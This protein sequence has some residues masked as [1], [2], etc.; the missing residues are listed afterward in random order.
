[1]RIHLLKTLPIYFQET[2]IGLKTFEVRKNDR[3]FDVAD[4]IVLQEWEQDIGYSGREIV[5]EATY[6]LKGDGGPLGIRE[7]YC[8]MAME[9]VQR[10]I[11]AKRDEQDTE[12]R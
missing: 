4:R 2:W 6:I 10:I 7:G 1:M 12:D 11:G 5:C 9:I 8:V 3:G